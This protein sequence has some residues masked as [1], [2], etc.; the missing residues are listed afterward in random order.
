MGVVYA[1]EDLNLGRRVALKFLPPELEH[2]PHALERFR[3]EAR[4]ASALNH[5]NICTI[6]DIAQH[7]GRY[8]IAMEFLEG[9]T[10]KHRI[11]EKPLSLPLLLSLAV[12]IADALDAAHEKGII[13]RDIKPANI[14]VTTR[15]HAKI[16]DFGLA[17]Q[18]E[19]DAG[20]TEADLTRDAEATLDV[21]HLT[22]AGTTLGTVAY[23]SPE[24]ARGEPLDARSDLFSF[25]TVLYEMATRTLPFPGETNAVI[26]NGILE[27]QPIPPARLNPDVPLKL[28]EIAEKAL[29]K[30]RDLRYQHASEMR[31]DLQRLRRDIDPS[32]TSARGMMAA[33]DASSG[34]GVYAAGAT[35]QAGTTPVSGTTPALGTTPVFGTTPVMG[36][37][38]ASGTAPAAPTAKRSTL[39]LAAVAVVALAAIG[40]GAWFYLNR[41]PKLT[42]KDTIVLADFSN[43]TGQAVFDGTLKQA[44]LVQLSQSP[45]LNILPRAR[46]QQTLR[47]MGQ[48]ADAAITSEMAREI[49]ERTSSAATLDGSISMLGS[50]YVIGLNAADCQNG[51]SLAREQV[52]ANRPEDVLAALGNAVTKLRARLGESLASIQQF[53]T[54]LAEA[55]TSSLP[56]LKAFSTAQ[57]VH[58]QKGDAAAI[59]YFKQA[60]RL[61]PN[62]A[63]AYDG[64]GIAYSN[65]GEFSL[66][67]EY[68]TK[69]Y[70]LR[71]RV[72]E[73]ER[74]MITAMYNNL[75]SGDLDAARQA[76]Q[77]WEQT[78]PRDFTAPIDLG[79]LYMETGQFDSAVNQT[80]VSIRLNPENPIEYS[81][82][83][84]IYLALGRLDDARSTLDE[85]RSR[86][87]D[88]PFLHV[89]HYLLAFAQNDQA[90]MKKQAAWAVGKVGSEDMF[91][92]FESDTAAYSGRLAEA[93][94]LDQQAVAT[95]QRDGMG[96]DAW[97]WNLDAALHE[98]E[99]GDP[100]RARQIA[101]ELL[102]TPGI[103][104]YTEAVA[105]LAL[106][107]A[108]DAAGAQ[109]VVASL[110]TQFPGDT[111]INSY[112]L[113]TLRAA[114]ALDRGDAAQALQALQPTASYQ[115]GLVNP[116]SNYSTL[117]PVFLR[118]LA[119]LEEKQGKQAAAAFQ[120][121][122]SHRGAV[123]N[124]PIGALAQLDLARAQ[125]LAGDSSAART[126]Y[127]NF[128]A[129]W[130]HADPGISILQ[131][132]KSEYAK[133]Q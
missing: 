28:E 22:S 17:K 11:G 50:Q 84:Q 7:E 6:Y 71:N 20:R 9:Q 30:D 37:T 80:L 126:S 48:P 72:S 44:L 132:A 57:T 45:F 15:G 35:P 118:G 61:D 55:T 102:K 24:Q 106:A 109:A 60:I 104:R 70:A 56:A 29:E 95:A 99:L 85:A 81:N 65:L 16:L 74:L 46:V 53:N 121:I 110:S 10:L 125:A 31:A 122:L 3:R 47:L 76:Y 98:A 26:F 113:P 101:G 87:F 75:A 51:N 19:Q 73:R 124:F 108:G 21:A 64:L 111:V 88:Y 115:I 79:S 103:D 93:R 114:I 69:A 8:F 5:P 83:A 116:F 40:A 27:K 77:Q 127:Q 82:L 42:S 131:Q 130:Q 4:A 86:H 89:T 94:N 43:T 33:P 107:R 52:T 34:A 49:C 54:P 67:A 39:W 59:P 18:I 123:L 12:E 105:A 32:R 13:H 96:E 62:F 112:W 91:L 2:S 66:A 133:L 36:T 97:L 119:L 100:A 38:P 63:L 23:M 90:G 120:F 68:L 78:F 129:L 117:Y 128:F 41:G 1:A 58:N 25:G 14:F 92:S